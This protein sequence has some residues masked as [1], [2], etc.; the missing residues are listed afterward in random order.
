MSEERTAPPTESDD[1]QD[2][3]DGLGRFEALTK[4]LRAVPKDVIGKARANGRAD[5]RHDEAPGSP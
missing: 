1:F 4:R 5:L 2:H 3:N